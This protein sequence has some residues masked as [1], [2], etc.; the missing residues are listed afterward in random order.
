MFLIYVILVC[1]LGIIF[2]CLI[3]IVLML[4][5]EYGI[6]YMVGVNC[7]DK[8]WIDGKNG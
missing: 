6:E 5:L 8:R 2:V 1:S 4:K 7:L 3:F